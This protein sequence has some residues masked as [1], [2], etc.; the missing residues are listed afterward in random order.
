[1]SENAE[2]GLLVSFPD[3]SKTFVLGFEAG[4]IWEMLFHNT[5]ESNRTIHSEN[6]EVV[7]R[8]CAATGWRC[9]FYPVSDDDSWWV[10]E[11]EKS[12]KPGLEIVK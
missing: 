11:F 7:T 12:A 4:Q 1:M 6:R 8:M 2:Y 5:M 3:Q 10:A 9:S